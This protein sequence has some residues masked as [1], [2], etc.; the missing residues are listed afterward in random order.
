MQTN[1]F[2]KSGF[3]LLER[4]AVLV[5]IAILRAVA[6]PRMVQARA[7]K[8]RLACQGNLHWFGDGALGGAKF[9]WAIES[10]QA[11]TAIPADSDIFGPTLYIRS[12]PLRPLGGTY[13]LNAVSA[14]PTCSKSAAPDF[15]TY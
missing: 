1:S 11:F 3:T 6:V 2:S 14:K 8:R 12:K 5:V 13:S 9:A 15:H 7:T 10:K 4:L